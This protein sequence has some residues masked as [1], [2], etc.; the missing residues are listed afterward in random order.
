M[1]AG[2]IKQR[3]NVYGGISTLFVA[4]EQG[5]DTAGGKYAMVCE[6]HGIVVN[7]NRKAVGLKLIRTNDFCEECTGN[8]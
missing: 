5:L 8:I 3:K 7:T 2:V 4:S 6:K 1:L